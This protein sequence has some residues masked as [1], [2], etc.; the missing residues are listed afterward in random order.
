MI[1]KHYSIRQ[2]AAQ[3]GISLERTRQLV[4]SEPGVLRLTQPRR[5]PATREKVLWRIPESVAERIL[6]RAAN[7]PIKDGFR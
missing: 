2:L 1:E 7:P 4:M 6:R 3:L 5:K